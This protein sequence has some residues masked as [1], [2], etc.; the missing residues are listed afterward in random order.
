MGWGK[1][2]YTEQ[3]NRWSSKQNRFPGQR[4]PIDVYIEGDTGITQQHERQMN[5]DAVVTFNNKVRQWGRKVDKALRSSIAQWITTD[6]KLSSS[7]KQNYRHFGKA[8]T[9][10]E[11]ITSIGFGFREEGVYVHLGVGK[12]Y[13]MQG[14]TRI[15]TKKTDNKWNRHPKPWFNPVIAQHIPELEQIVQEYCGNLVVN[16]M[17]IFIN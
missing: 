11:E 9:A 17:N 3:S 10:G 2:Q 14:G 6:N 12:G 5:K 13:N 1:R 7:L 15:L 8:P 4:Y 16:T